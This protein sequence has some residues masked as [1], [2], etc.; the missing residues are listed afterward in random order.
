MS[1]LSF[2]MSLTPH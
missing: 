1:P 2:I